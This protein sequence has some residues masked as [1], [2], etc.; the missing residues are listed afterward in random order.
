MP[1]GLFRAASGSAAVEREPQSQARD[2]A[3]VLGAKGGSWQVIAAS[4]Y[5]C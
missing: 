3:K 5:A 2:G 1:A 4:L